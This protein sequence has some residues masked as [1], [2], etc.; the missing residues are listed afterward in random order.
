[1][2]FGKALELLKQG[3]KLARVGWNGKGMFINL[4]THTIYLSDGLHPNDE[5]AK[6][7]SNRISQ[8]LLNY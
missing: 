4:Y 6:L 1:M 8:F 7:L 3:K 2:N 5:G